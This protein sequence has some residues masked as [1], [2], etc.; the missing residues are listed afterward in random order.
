MTAAAIGQGLV[1]EPIVPLGWCAV[2]LAGLLAALVWAA[3][4]RAPPVSGRRRAVLAILRFAVAGCAAMLLLRPAI[5][6]RGREV[7]PSQV[8]V[9]LDASRSQQIRDEA[10][11]PG[12]G[13]APDEAVMRAQAVRDAFIAADRALRD[14]SARHAVRLFAFGSRLRPIDTFAPVSGDP[15]TLVAEALD[16]V[17]EPG[18]ALAAVILVSDGCAS[19]EVG[20][21]P[22]EAAARLAAEGIPVH[23]VGVGS[24]EPSG[25]A[26][27]VAVRDLRAP[28]RVFARGPSSASGPPRARPRG[29]ASAGRADGSGTTGGR[30]RGRRGMGLWQE[31]AGSR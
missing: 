20:R 10:A 25:R 13:R 15:R 31:I 5:N 29:G 28:A 21:S 3:W 27:D 2:V 12:R 17:L 4:R 16:G 9:L 26:R 7:R 8:A 24:T 22:E 23:A 6:R 30:A 19:P 18:S 1:L 14:L 11:P